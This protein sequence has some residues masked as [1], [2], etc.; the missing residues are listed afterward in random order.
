MGDNSCLILPRLCLL[1]QRCR[2]AF[3]QVEAQAKEVFGQVSAGSGT[4]NRNWFESSAGSPS[5]N[6][7]TRVNTPNSLREIR[8][9]GAIWSEH[10]TGFTPRSALPS[11]APPLSR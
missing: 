3:M 6:A 4:P 8:S 5:R 2:V 10:R 9:A 7:A 1:V 11:R